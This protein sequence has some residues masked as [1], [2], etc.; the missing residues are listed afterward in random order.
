MLQGIIAGKGGGGVITINSMLGQLAMSLGHGVISSETHGMAMRGGSVSTSIKI[1]SFLSP[2]IESGTAAFILSLDADEA[3]RNIQYLKEGGL[4]IINTTGSRPQIIPNEYRV[5][6]ID[7]VGMAC[8]MFN[9]S[10]LA[11]QIMI[12]RLIKSFPA[13]FPQDECL[14]ILSSMP[15][16]FPDAIKAGFLHG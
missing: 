3:V 10:I 15:R 6:T 5:D 2:S 4:C 8:S 13:V 16:S 7:A 14:A 11:G 9:R 12:G 1:G